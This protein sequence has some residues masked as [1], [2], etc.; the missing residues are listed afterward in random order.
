MLKRIKSQKAQMPSHIKTISHFRS[1]IIVF[2]LSISFSSLVQSAN[3]VEVVGKSDLSAGT[4]VARRMALVDAYRKAIEEGGLVKVSSKTTVRDFELLADV[5]TAKASGYINSYEILSEGISKIDSSFYSIKIK[6]EIVDSSEKNKKAL[7][8]LI[9]VIGTPKILFLISSNENSSEDII[10]SAEHNFAQIFNQVGYEVITSDLISGLEALTT[11]DLINA[12]KGE[13]Q[14]LK[15][16]AAL[17][18]SDLILT[19]HISTQL[20]EMSGGTDIKAKV[21]VVTLSSKVLSPSNGKIIDVSNSQEKFMSLQASSTL[22]AT[23]KS[24]KKAVKKIANKFKWRIPKL[25][26]QAPKIIQLTINKINFVNNQAFI[27]K[28]Q[29]INGINHVEFISW[30]KNISHAQLS[31]EFIGPKENDIAQSISMLNS[32]LKVL[33]LSNNTIEVTF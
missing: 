13:I 21:G 4:K 20:N 29:S 7:S 3:W 22:H 30:K 2:I 5:V 19:G 31:V 11:K 6:A 14:A 9:D 10:R 15:K 18:Q 23:E 1:L 12:R 24:I 8:T 17:S 25:L 32:K 28:L 26:T 16:I 27:K 33:N